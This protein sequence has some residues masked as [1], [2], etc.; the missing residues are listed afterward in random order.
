MSKELKKLKKLIKESVID[1]IQQD[2]LF[3]HGIFDPPPA[4]LKSPQHM[5]ALRA[6][7]GA[8]VSDARK[9]QNKTSEIA[10]P[11]S[12]KQTPLQRPLFWRNG[13][14][15]IKQLSGTSAGPGPLTKVA[16]LNERY[17]EVYTTQL[18]SD[19][20]NKKPEAKKS[21]LKAVANQIN[22]AKPSKKGGS[23]LALLYSAAE[24]LENEGFLSTGTSNK[25]YNLLNKR[26]LFL[27]EKT[28]LKS[29]RQ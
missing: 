19:L 28:G 29:N 8:A 13:Q 23:P 21:F 6:M 14:D 26:D 25:I 17:P 4:E 16:M 15:L 11:Q 9:Q 2:K 18:L 12:N 3:R 7:V 27:E 5:Q 1:A 24:A 22:D 10:S 20:L